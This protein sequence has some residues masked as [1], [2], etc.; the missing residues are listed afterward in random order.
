MNKHRILIYDANEQDSLLDETW[1]TGAYLGRIFGRYDEIYGVKT[2]EQAINSVTNKNRKIDE[3]HYW[4]HGSP[5]RVVIGKVAITVED[6]IE[7]SIFYNL[8]LKL[9]NNITNTSLIW[10]RTCST[11][12]KQEGKIF[13]E[14]YSKF[15]GCKIASQTFK[16]AFWQSG[17]HTVS[18]GVIIK[19]DCNEGIIKDNSGEEVVALSSFGKP[20]TISCLR[21]SIPNNW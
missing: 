3:L 1:K 19:W 4:G 10:F 11:F 15:F 8:F 9:K 20:H 18:P 13:A 14:E 6:L 16:I 12:A 5:G 17:I 2:W 21:S 7:G